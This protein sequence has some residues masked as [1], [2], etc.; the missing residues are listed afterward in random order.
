MLSA[1]DIAN[2]FV[3]ISVKGKEND[4]TNLKL[5][6]LVYYAQAWSFVKLGHGIFN[7]KVEAWDNGPVVPS[8]YHAFKKYG[9]NII[10]NTEKTYKP[11]IFTAEEIDF[12]LEIDENYSKYSASELVRQTHKIG[13]PWQSV[14]IP[15]VKNIEIPPEKMKE[16]YSDKTLQSIKIDTSSIPEIGKRGKDGV[17]VL[18]AEEYCKE[19][20]IY[21]SYLEL[22][23]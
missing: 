11:E 14:Y 21:N 8:V 13:S 5:N 7:E 23:G 12:L 15:D 9:K 1:L 19:D 2:F 10:Q 17:I 18:P 20:D 16:Y 3:D 22:R 6:K 4:I